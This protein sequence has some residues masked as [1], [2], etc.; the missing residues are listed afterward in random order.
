MAQID[1]IDMKSDGAHGIV[2]I[3]SEGACWL[4]FSRPSWDLA[5]H[6]WFWLSPGVKK[7]I[8][9]RHTNGRKTRVK[10]VCLANNHVRIAAS[11]TS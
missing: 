11:K 10:A 2:I 1:I 9:V 7:W 8:I 3:D 5:S 4:T 6:I